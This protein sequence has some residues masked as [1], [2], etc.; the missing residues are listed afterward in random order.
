LIGPIMY[1]Y[2]LS[3]TRTKTLPEGLTDQIVDSFW[4]AHAITMPVRGRAR[5]IRRSKNSGQK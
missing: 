1:S 2:F 4:K 3:P 5:E